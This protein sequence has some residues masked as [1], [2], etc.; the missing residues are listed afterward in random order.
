MAIP[1]KENVQIADLIHNSLKYIDLYIKPLEYI[2]NH[3]EWLGT[4]WEYPT[5]VLQLGAFLAGACFFLQKVF[6][7]HK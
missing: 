6:W 4:G 2:G 1:S 7:K 5:Y 3:Q